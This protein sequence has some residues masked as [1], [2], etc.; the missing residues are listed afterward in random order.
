V[1][2]FKVWAVVTTSSRRSDGVSAAAPL[3]KPVKDRW[4]RVWLIRWWPL[5]TMRAV[6]ALL[7]LAHLPVSPKLAGTP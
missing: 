1:I 4:V 5:A 2:A 3:L 6:R 7:A